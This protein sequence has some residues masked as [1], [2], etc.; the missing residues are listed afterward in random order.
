MCCQKSTAQ[1]RPG[2]ITACAVRNPQLRIRHSCVP[3]TTSS[4]AVD[5]FLFLLLF[6]FVCVCVCVCCVPLSNAVRNDMVPG[7]WCGMMGYIL[8]K[9]V[10]SVGW[11]GRRLKLLK[12]PSGIVGLFSCQRITVENSLHEPVCP[13]NSQETHFSDMSWSWACSVC[14]N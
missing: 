14:R 6:C 7:G 11:F 2:F 5:E 9:C 10:R 13:C 1:D 12:K 3:L 4:S 8:C